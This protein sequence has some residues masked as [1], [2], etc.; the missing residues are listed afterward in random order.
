MRMPTFNKKEETS[1]CLFCKS[2]RVPIKKWNKPC[3]DCKKKREKKNTRSE[4]QIGKRQPAAVW[5]DPD[6]NRIF[7]DKFGKP[8]QDHGY[9]LDGDPRGY[10]TTGKMPP[11]KD[12]II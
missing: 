1:I 11:K 12:F 2:N 3:E 8:V 4:V 6:G 5:E 10:K 9:D 7:V